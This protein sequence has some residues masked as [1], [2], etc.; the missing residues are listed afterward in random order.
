MSKQTL[1]TPI[2]MRNIT[3]IEPAKFV[4]FEDEVVPCCKLTLQFRNADDTLYAEVCVVAFDSQNSTA[5]LLNP[6]STGYMD[7][8]LLAQVQVNNAYTQ[9]LAAYNGASGTRG[10]KRD[11]VLA[12]AKSIGLVDPVGFAST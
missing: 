1:T 11:A 3:R 4:A 7:K 6:T 9:L 8:I 12:A 2:N 10:Q 5:M